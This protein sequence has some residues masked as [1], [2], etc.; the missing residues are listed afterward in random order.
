MEPKALLAKVRAR[1]EKK[2]DLDETHKV[3]FLRP[4][5]TEM[6]ELLSV[7]GD[8]RTWSVDVSHVKR[9][10]VGWEG[11]T[12]EDALGKGVGSTDPLEFSAEL[13]AE[14]VGDRAEWS[15]KVAAAI[16]KAV[17]SHVN[18]KAEAE[19]NSVPA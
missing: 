18:G 6:S 13:W 19:K 7:D 10:V 1:R 2:V 3:T 12:E 4:P 15:S 11:F 16:L 5:E 8:Q 9:F 14:M 17:V